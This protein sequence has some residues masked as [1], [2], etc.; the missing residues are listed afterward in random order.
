MTRRVFRGGSIFLA[1]ALVWMQAL[2]AHAIWVN[3]TPEQAERAMKVGGFQASMGNPSKFMEKWTV[4]IEGASALLMTEF[5]SVAFAAQVAAAN[6]SALQPWE[7]QDALGRA[8]GKLVFS[9]TTTGSA[10][11]FADGQ[12][13]WVVADGKRIQNSHWK[14]GTP[15]KTEDG[16]YIADSTFWFLAEGISPESK[17]ELV[18]E[19]DDTGKTWSFPF[20][21]SK[22]R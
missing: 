7:V 20:D 18:I 4:S 11:D 17:V 8:R 15:T 16:G 21:L 14:N 5:L 9:V 12:R 6:M 1:M 10:P 13:G 3:L 2:P 22:M 19:N